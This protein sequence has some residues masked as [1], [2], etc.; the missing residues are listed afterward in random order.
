MNV[1]FCSKHINLTNQKVAAIFFSLGNDAI[2]TQD[3]PECHIFVLPKST[4]SGNSD[5]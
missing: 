5:R 3:L 1:T 4:L 2:T